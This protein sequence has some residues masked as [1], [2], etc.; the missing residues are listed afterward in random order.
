MYGNIG[1]A[2]YDVLKVDMCLTVIP[3]LR[4]ILKSAAQDVAYEISGDYA[5]EFAVDYAANAII[6]ELCNFLTQSEVIVE[7]EP[8][9]HL[10]QVK[11]KYARAFWNVK[12]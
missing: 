4:K 11:P 1:R 7:D 9:I 5:D 8:L 2:A 3:Q 12:K 6:H 10:S